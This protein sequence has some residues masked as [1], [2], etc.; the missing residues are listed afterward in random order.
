MDQQQISE[1]EK[2]IL[3]DYDNIAGI[4]VER[5]GKTLYENYFNEC[6]A[7]TA[8]H[9]FSVTKSIISILIGIALDKGFINS[10]DQK[11]L[12]FF[13]DYTAK[14]GERTMQS[15]LIKTMLTMTAPYKYKSSPYTKYFTDD[16]NVRF[17][18]DVLG[19]KTPIGKFRY[20]PIVGPDIL[21]GILVKA[22]GQSLLDFARKYLFNPLGITVAS[23][24]T[25][26]T[27]EEL[28]AFY[29]AK[30]ISGWVAGSKGVNTAGWGLTLT[31]ADMAKIGQLYLN[32]GKWDDK[33]IV[34]APRAQKN[35]ADGKNSIYL[36]VTCGG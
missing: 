9:V 1:L 4:V 19:G 25:F 27:K 15:V 7:N 11:V 33:Q 17:S 23:N 20:A 22:T 30:G 8:I 16:D 12:D 13:P 21:S 6:S 5:D 2:T 31:T 36:T 10:I 14:R 34:S 28:F 18:L 24:V 3:S 26:E 32:G 35:I 29:N